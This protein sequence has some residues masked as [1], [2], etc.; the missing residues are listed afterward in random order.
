MQPK[1]HGASAMQC[2]CSAH[3]VQC[4]RSAVPPPLPCQCSAQCC[5]EPLPAHD[6][7]PA[8][9]TPTLAVPVLCQCSGVPTSAGPVKLPAPHSTPP[10]TPPVSPPPTP[11]ASAEQ[12]PCSARAVPCPFQCPCSARAVRRA[13]GGGCSPSSSSGAPAMVAAGGAG[14]GRTWRAGEAEPRPRAQSD[15]VR[16]SVCPAVGDGVGTDPG[17]TPEDGGLGT[18]VRGGPRP[19]AAGLGRGR[20][21]LMAAAPR[22]AQEGTRAGGAHA[23]AGNTRVHVA[24]LARG[25]GRGGYR[26]LFWEI[27]G[28]YWGVWGGGD[29]GHMGSFPGY[30]GNYWDHNRSYWGYTGRYW[31]HTGGGV[32][33]LGLYWELLAPQR[34]ILGPYWGGWRETGA[35]LGGG[36]EGDWDYTGNFW[37]H[38]GGVGGGRLRLY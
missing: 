24:G 36:E 31:G 29:W 30:T 12:G 23:C 16:P 28:P 10:S 2:P 33:R 6:Q 37:S 18:G 14:G 5:T 21:G 13:G 19:K 8:T 15:S 9:R 25:R 27:L 20:K 34:K 17:D 7:S 1:P 38:A 3:A 32:A 4:P 26:G 22:G 11:S 35:I